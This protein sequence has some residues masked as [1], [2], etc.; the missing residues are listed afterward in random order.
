MK[1]SHGK[2]NG[3]VFSGFLNALCSDWIIQTIGK[4]QIR[5]RAATVDTVVLSDT[6]SCA[7]PH[8]VFS[9]QKRHPMNC[10]PEAT[11]AAT[12]S[13]SGPIHDPL[14]RHAR[15]T[16]PPANRVY[17]AGPV[18]VQWSCKFLLSGDVAARTSQWDGLLPCLWRHWSERTYCVPVLPSASHLIVTINESE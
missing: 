3:R 8:E 13:V 6:T 15:L 10:Y 7:N 2:G 5:K 9:R 12:I 18:S 16:F 17:D 11:N 1:M 4:G 14:C